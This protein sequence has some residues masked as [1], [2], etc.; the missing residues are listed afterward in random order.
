MRK[1]QIISK[2]EKIY[3]NL[4]VLP[5]TSNTEVIRNILVDI[6]YLESTRKTEEYLA[7]VRAIKPLTDME[8]LLQRRIIVC[9]E[10]KAALRTHIGPRLN[11]FAKNKT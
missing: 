9:L 8:A 5:E 4:A 6:T 2:L 3:Q 10:E 11:I 7:Q 1:E